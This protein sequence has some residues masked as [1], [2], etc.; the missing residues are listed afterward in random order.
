MSN[1]LFNTIP[2]I[3]NSNLDNLEKFLEITNEIAKADGVNVKI[4]FVDAKDLTSETFDEQMKLSIKSQASNELAES[5]AK[6]EFYSDLI[7][8]TLVY[9]YQ[10]TDLPITQAASLTFEHIKPTAKVFYITEM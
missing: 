10:L 4:S 7:E 8:L 6:S 5:I 2:A 9:W 3:L 1:T